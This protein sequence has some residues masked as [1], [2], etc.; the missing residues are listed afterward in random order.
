MCRAQGCLLNH[1][2]TISEAHWHSR[3]GLCSPLK[4]FL[5][6][7]KKCQCVITNTESLIDL[8]KFILLHLFQFSRLFRKPD[9]WTRRALEHDELALDESKA[10][11]GE[12][13]PAVGL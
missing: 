4:Y 13:D 10:E 11:D 5:N 7:S 9:T 8:V 3:I 1:L 12:P 2:L 6:K